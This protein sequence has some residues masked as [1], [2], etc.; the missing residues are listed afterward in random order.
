MPTN[1]SFFKVMP[2]LFYNLPCGDVRGN[3]IITLDFWEAKDYNKGVK[4]IHS[5]VP[6][7]T[8]K[9]RAVLAAAKYGSLS[10]AAQEFS[11]TPSAF[12]HMLVTFEKELGVRIFERSSKGVTL[13]LSPSN[14]SGATAQ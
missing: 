13:S 6:M 3:F 8:V 5:E 11:Y 4:N 7:D 14:P 9:I 1:I 12:S 10:K 2:P